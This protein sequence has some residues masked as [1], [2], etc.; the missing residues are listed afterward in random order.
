LQP[1]EWQ[2]ASGGV[3]VTKLLYELK[4]RNLRYGLATLCIGGGQGLALI[5]ENK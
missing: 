3:I 5:V 1:V 4:A 2:S